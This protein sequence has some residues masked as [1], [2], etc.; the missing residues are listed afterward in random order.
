M[1]RRELR[2]NTINASRSAVIA[3]M[4]FGTTALFTSCKKNNTAEEA[5]NNKTSLEVQTLK[6]THG[7]KEKVESNLYKFSYA[8]S[9][10]NVE[11]L[12]EGLEKTT[13]KFLDEFEV[14]KDTEN[15]Y[16]IVSGDQL[17]ELVSDD[18]NLYLPNSDSETILIHNSNCGYAISKSDTTPDEMISSH[19]STQATATEVPV[20]FNNDFTS[21][22]MIKTATVSTV[23]TVESIM[24]DTTAILDALNIEYKVGSDRITVQRYNYV[25]NKIQPVYM[26]LVPKGAYVRDTFSNGQEGNN[27]STGTNLEFAG[28]YKEDDVIYTDLTALINVF[29]LS[30]IQEDNGYIIHNNSGVYYEP[31]KYDGISFNTSN[32]PEPAVTEAK[33]PNIVKV[34]DANYKG[35]TGSVNVNNYDP[36]E[37]GDR[38]ASTSSNIHQRED[39]VWIMDM[40]PYRDLDKE[41]KSFTEKEQEALLYMG[42][43]I[44]HSIDHIACAE[45]LA[46]VLN[47][48]Y[49]DQYGEDIFYVNEYGSCKNKLFSLSPELHPLAQQLLDLVPASAEHEAVYNQLYAE[50]EAYCN[51]HGWDFTKYTFPELNTLASMMTEKMYIPGTYDVIDFDDPNAVN[52]TQ[53]DTRWDSWTDMLVYASMSFTEYE[54]Y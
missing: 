29:G 16:F 10:S 40:G 41:L 39:G 6:D 22:E 42:V 18:N 15:S 1:T 54:V 3:V 35:N 38:Y 31:I 28:S 8:N 34:T 12:V 33:K 20:V 49:H 11:S 26:A 53:W 13:L 5:N 7:T 45:N 47:A 43:R 23:S 19:L 48:K 4:C 32:E 46:K 21:C 36:A 52:T 25:E 2:N 24:L 27:P 50:A 17:V 37:W 9:Q 44:P 30:I 14:Y 51:E